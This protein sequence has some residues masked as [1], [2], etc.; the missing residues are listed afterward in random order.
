M[1]VAYQGS[2]WRQTERQMKQDSELR[3]IRCYD[4]GRM[5]S[6]ELP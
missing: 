2:S 6:F 1:V 4:L 5:G 3:V